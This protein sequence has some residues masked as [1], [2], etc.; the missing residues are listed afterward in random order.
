METSWDSNDHYDPIYT[1]LL[2]PDEIR[3][4]E[5]Y[6]GPMRAIPLMGSLIVTTLRACEA[7]LINR[8]TALSYVWGGAASSTPEDADAHTITLAGGSEKLAITANLSAALKDIRH[9]SEVMTVWVDAVC[10]NQTDIVERG[11]QVGLMHEIYG[12]ASSTIIYLGPLNPGVS[13]IFDAA[14]R[15]KGER[16]GL[17]EAPPEPSE[18]S[19]QGAVNGEHPDEVDDD[20]E[21]EEEAAADA[22]E[23]QAELLRRAVEEDLCTYPW[24]CRGW[25]LQELMLSKDPRI[26]CGGRRAAWNEIMDVVEPF[27]SV[28]GPTC[29]LYI[30]HNLRSRGLRAG[31]SL[32]HLM[33]D[34]QGSHVTDPRDLFFSLMGLASDYRVYRKFLVPD[35]SRPVRQVYIA[36]ARYM[37]QQLGLSH[38]LTYAAESQT[39]ATQ[40]S[41]VLDLPSWV[42]DWGVQTS[43]TT[44]TQAENEMTTEPP[45][46][47]SEAESPDEEGLLVVEEL[48]IFGTVERIANVLPPGVSSYSPP[49]FPPHDGSFAGES[50]STQGV[51]SVGPFEDAVTTVADPLQIPFE[52]PGSGSG[53]ADSHMDL[54]RIPKL[55]S[56]LVLVVNRDGPDAGLLQSRYCSIPAPASVALGD[57]L[58][59]FKSRSDTSILQV[60]DTA[61]SRFL[62]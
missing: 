31:N 2:E 45:I 4:L 25:I 43:L 29:H 13:L 18:L 28:A 32:Y 14:V 3:L 27:I 42:P 12:C 11:R 33:M 56:R 10:I 21:E 57:T 36:A 34:R 37:L 40:K 26:Q 30:L 55:C 48:A 50:H 54:E 61:K 58:I 22:E 15:R 60:R 62:N 16:M 19:I 59:A 39:E 52:W 23:R 46:T 24:F 38:F 49:S 53:D 1:D 9:T 5:L 20:D 47:S 41:N 7:D 51:E 17:R 35:Y 44:I 8:Y 6:P